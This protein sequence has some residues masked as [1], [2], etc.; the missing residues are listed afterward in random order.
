MNVGLEAAKHTLQVTTQQGI[1]TAVHPFHQQYWVDQSTPEIV[2][3]KQGLV[4]RYP[5]ILESDI[6]AR[7]HVC[8]YVHQRQF[9]HS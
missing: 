8:T 1:R 9:Q 6:Y 2:M 7:Q 5:T 3:P 4:P